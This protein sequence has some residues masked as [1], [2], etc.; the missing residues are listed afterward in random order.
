MAFLAVST[1]VYGFF[2]A[3]Y[4]RTWRAT[5]VTSIAAPI[6]YLTAMGVGLG[7]IVHRSSSLGGSYLHFVAPA[8]LAAT[9][10]QVGASEST[11]AVLGS[12]KWVP[13]Y[14]AMAATPL[15][16][17]NILAGHLMWMATRITMASA[18]YLGIIAAFGGIASPLGV[19]A[20]PTGVLVG[21][22]VA[23]PITAFSSTRQNDG[24][25]PPIYRFGVVPMFLF[26][27]TFFPV[28]QLP[29]GVRPIAYATPLWHGVSLARGLARGHVTLGG[30]AVHVG[31]LALWVVVG[32]A[33][34]LRFYRRR[35][36]T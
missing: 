20:L 32:V 14:H 25:F 24:G 30:A 21:M 9:A 31:Y 7:S 2:F 15:T 26:S 3:V 36:G 19:L 27:G 16:P 35:L 22:A 29:A 1:R 34:A 5:V 12:F 28:S 18:V 4:R 23:A 17:A 11:Y 6:M 13:T 8:L 33:L 10:M